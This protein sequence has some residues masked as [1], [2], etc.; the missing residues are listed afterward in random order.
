MTCQYGYEWKFARG[1]TVCVKHDGE[2][3]TGKYVSLAPKRSDNN[4]HTHPG[5]TVT[6][7][8]NNYIY[9]NGDVGKHS[10]GGRRKTRRT[11]KSRK[12]R[13]SFRRTK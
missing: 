4:P 13:R 10:A 8:G 7:D 11:K 6:V 12:T 1:E 3:K 9:S 2:D 5:H